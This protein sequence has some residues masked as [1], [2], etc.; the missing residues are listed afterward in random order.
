MVG[1]SVVF[2]NREWVITGLLGKGKSAYSW[3]AESAGEAVV[4]KKMHQETVDYY[5]FG[6]KLKAEVEA[7]ERILPTGIRIPRLLAWSD[8]D[9][10]LIKEYLH[11]PTAADL[12]AAGELTPVHWG[13]IF[14]VQNQLKAGGLHV[15]Y[16]PT[17]FIWMDGQ[18]IL[19]DYECHSYNRE[20]DFPNWGIFYWLNSPGIKEQL[21]LGSTQKL[22]LPG[23]PKPQWQEFLETR[24]RL[25]AELNQETEKSPDLVWTC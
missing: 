17:N 15:D 1:K 8:K 19:I 3:L 23:R 4:F 16:F 25:L 6:N 2:K 14:G 11:G 10:W 5:T 18:M 7:Y 13:A 20:W 12:A 21:E 22:N 24:D 9:Q